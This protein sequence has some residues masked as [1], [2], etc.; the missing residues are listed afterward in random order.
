LLTYYQLCINFKHE[1]NSVQI[2]I[3]DF[4]CVWSQN[5]GLFNE[6]AAPCTPPPILV[7]HECLIFLLYENH[8][9]KYREMIIIVY[10]CFKYFIDSCNTGWA[11]VVWFYLTFTI[12]LLVT[13][14]LYTI[15]GFILAMEVVGEKT[16]F[17]LT[18]HYMVVSSYQTL[19]SYGD[20]MNSVIFVWSSY[21]TSV[22]DSMP[23]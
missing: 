8:L 15:Y 20:E 5:M 13:I 22:A 14:L 19:C 11:L 16:L 18:L 12:W 4:F 6:G 1:K 2:F 9:L 3:V 10:C 7:F 21:V 23:T 17:F